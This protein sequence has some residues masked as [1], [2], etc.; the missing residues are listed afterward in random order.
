MSIKLFL[1]F[2]IVI[3]STIHYY[4]KFKNEKED[5]IKNFPPY[6]SECP[7]N[8]IKIKTKNGVECKSRVT[9]K[10]ENFKK[11]TENLDKRE[12]RELLCQWVHDNNESWIGIENLC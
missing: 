9:G 5:E 1:F 8:W 10:I 11:M 7:D 4:K 6:V 3:G 12:A 2:A